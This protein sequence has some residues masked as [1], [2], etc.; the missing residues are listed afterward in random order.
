MIGTTIRDRRVERGLTQRQLANLAGCERSHVANLE[1]GR[2]LP[3]FRLLRTIA[4]AL[5]LDL[6]VLSSES[7]DSR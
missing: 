4:W 6:G 5:G 1:A 3:S 7:S 2:A